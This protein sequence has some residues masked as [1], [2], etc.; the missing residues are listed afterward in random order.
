[1]K[2]SR[3]VDK[4]ING[5]MIDRIQGNLL[6]GP[7]RVTLTE[8]EKDRL[9]DIQHCLEF[10]E[11]HNG[12]RTL[13]IKALTSRPG[14]YCSYH[15][16]YSIL[17]DLMYLWPHLNQ[18][19]FVLN[20]MIK[21]ERLTKSIDEAM[22]DKQYK[23]VASLEEAHLKVITEI[24]R[25][26]NRRKKPEKIIINLH[27]DLTRIGLTNEKYDSMH[28]RLQEIIAT[29]KSKYRGFDKIEEAEYSDV[30]E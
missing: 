30:T 16:A 22:K 26:F 17:Q 18:F 4:F 8:T 7:D 27:M 13:V 14:K 20:L 28:N 12:N 15:E 23:A 24:E 2:P 5:S 25:V 6:Y 21:A 11:Q 10:W 1:M 19:D 29:V 9:E 3:T